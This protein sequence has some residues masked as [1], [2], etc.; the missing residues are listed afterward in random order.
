[1]TITIGEPELTG[2]VIGAPILVNQIRVLAPITVTDMGRSGASLWV[3]E[4]VPDLV[5]GSQVGDEYL[6]K[7][8]GIIY[9]LNEGQ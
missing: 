1:M 8:T 2:I 7:L 4:G 5:P 9:T 3:G 6:D